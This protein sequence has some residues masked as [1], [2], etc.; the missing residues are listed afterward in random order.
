M[1]D[2]ANAIANCAHEFIVFK[3]LVPKPTWS[4]V[5]MTTRM[6]N[7]QKLTPSAGIA[8]LLR[9][10]AVTIVA[11]IDRWVKSN[12]DNATPPELCSGPKQDI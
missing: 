1:P 2:T 10:V 4:W 6:L 9:V 3:F 12:F 7:A 8:V 5:A 11:C